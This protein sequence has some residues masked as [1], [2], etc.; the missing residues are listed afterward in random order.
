MLTRVKLW[1]SWYEKIYFLKLHM[2]LYLHTIFQVSSIILKAKR[3]PK[4]PIQTRVNANFTKIPVSEI[5]G[6]AQLQR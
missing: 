6:G 3:I 1:E 2:Y 4:N 5:P